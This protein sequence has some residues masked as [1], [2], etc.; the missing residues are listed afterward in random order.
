MGRFEQ[1]NCPRLRI[2]GWIY[3]CRLSGST[4]FRSL[5]CHCLNKP[6]VPFLLERESLTSPV[7]AFRGVV[8]LLFIASHGF[9]YL[10]ITNL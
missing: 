6:P 10:V 5:S 2:R 9:M 1:L 4:V 3:Q 8:Y 7:I